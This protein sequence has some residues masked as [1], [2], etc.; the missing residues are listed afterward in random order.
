[1]TRA[2]SCSGRRR[3]GLSP[4][5][6]HVGINNPPCAGLQGTSV[7]PGR[8]QR[9]PTVRTN[10]GRPS[11][12]SGQDPPNPLSFLPLH[13]CRPGRFRP[14]STCPTASQPSDE[15]CALLLP[16]EDVEWVSERPSLQRAYERVVSSRDKPR[17]QGAGALLGLWKAAQRVKTHAPVPGAFWGWECARSGGTT[18][19]GSKKRTGVSST[20]RGDEHSAARGMGGLCVSGAWD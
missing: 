7:S 19:Q 20:T 18:R 11:V 6:R 9:D 13:C 1:M 8:Q 17:H 15:A 12:L 4:L 10:K 14:L 16:I 3:H 5:R 2:G